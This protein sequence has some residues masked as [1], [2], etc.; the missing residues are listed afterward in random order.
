MSLTESVAHDAVFPARDD[1]GDAVITAYRI[2][3]RKLLGEGKESA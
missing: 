3:T 1:P 2:P